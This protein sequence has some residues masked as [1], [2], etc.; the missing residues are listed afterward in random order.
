MSGATCAMHAVSWEKV[1]D[2]VSVKLFKYL[3]VSNMEILEAIGL[4][5]HFTPHD[6]RVTGKMSDSTNE[7]GIGNLIP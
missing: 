6:V 5:P 2:R 3:I 7:F 1:A 4:L